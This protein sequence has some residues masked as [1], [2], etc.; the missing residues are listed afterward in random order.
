[1]FLYRDVLEI[2]LVEFGRIERAPRRPRIPVVLSPRGGGALLA[3]L[4]NTTRLMAALLYGSGLRLNEAEVAR[5]GPRFPAREDNGARRQGQDRI[6]ML[7]YTLHP[8]LGA[9]G[10]RARASRAG[11]RRGHGR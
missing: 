1:M 6:T 4:R 10:A 11:P 9:P 7:R 8:D 3:Q 2:P 5:P